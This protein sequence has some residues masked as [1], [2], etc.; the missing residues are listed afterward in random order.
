MEKR[1]TERWHLTVSPSTCANRSTAFQSD[2]ANRRHLPGYRSLRQSA[3]PDEPTASLDTQE[4][5]LLF[6]LMLSFAIA[7]SA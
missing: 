6:G 3:D 4:V 7:A 2:A 1:A 5:E